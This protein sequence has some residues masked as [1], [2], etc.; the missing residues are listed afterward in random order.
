VV[1]HSK[2]TSKVLD[3]QLKIVISPWNQT[4]IQLANNKPF[5][6]FKVIKFHSDQVKGGGIITTNAWFQ[7]RSERFDPS[8][9]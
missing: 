6:I 4:N 3:D 9:H 1:V 7:N 8:F 5:F 2:M